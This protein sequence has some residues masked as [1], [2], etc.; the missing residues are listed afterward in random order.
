MIENNEILKCDMLRIFLVYRF[1]HLV[2][3]N[4]NDLTEEDRGNAKTTF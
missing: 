2:K 4:G 3:F 1:Q